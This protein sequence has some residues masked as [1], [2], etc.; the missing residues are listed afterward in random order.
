MSPLSLPYDGEIGR[1]QIAFHNS[2]C[3]PKNPF[4]KPYQRRIASIASVTRGPTKHRI[5]DTDKMEIESPSY[6]NGR[7]IVYDLQYVHGC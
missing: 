2:C 4:N 6:N 3:S 7:L 5:D 1:L